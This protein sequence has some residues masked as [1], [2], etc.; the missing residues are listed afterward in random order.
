MSECYTWVNVDKKEYISPGDFDC[1]LRFRESMN[2]DCLPLH[3]LHTLLSGEWKGDHL[4]WLGDECSV[5]PLSPY[6]II[7][8]LYAQ[9]ADFGTPGNAF[10]MICESYRNV[11][12]LFREAE[13]AVREEIGNYLEDLRDGRFEVDNVFGINIENPFEG[14]FGK[15]CRRSRYIVNHTKKVFY[16]L[17]ETAILFQDH[18][19]NDFSDPLPLLM[20]F[21]GTAESGEW[22]GDIIGVSDRRPE[23]YSL[24][25][26]I[27]VDW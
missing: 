23:A 11:S 25:E 1:G 9:S 2:K 8:T 4:V 15:T 24:L 10:D 16:T 7:Q 3:A 19:K 22:L 14:L 6:G 26:T 20:G 17:D 27:Y 18:T 21:G 12:C 5:S 13:H